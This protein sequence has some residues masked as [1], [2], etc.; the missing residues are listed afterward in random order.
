M[1][2]ISSDV[3]LATFHFR[4]LKSRT[5]MFLM[6]FP[7]RNGFR[8]VLFQQVI[9][10]LF[11]TSSV[12]KYHKSSGEWSPFGSCALEESGLEFVGWS[13]KSTAGSRERDVFVRLPP[14]YLASYSVSFRSCALPALIF[15]ICHLGKLLLWFLTSFTSPSTMN[16]EYY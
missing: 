5:W 7:R 11:E 1:V 10:F 6:S 8:H 4:R 13:H 12:A 3:Y 15:Y 14:H 2:K 16:K 9:D